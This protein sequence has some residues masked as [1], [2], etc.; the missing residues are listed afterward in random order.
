MKYCIQLV[1]F[2]TPDNLSLPGLLYEPSGKSEKVAIYLH[3]NGSSSIFYGDYKMNLYGDALTKKGI[4]FFPFNNRGAHWIKKLNKKING[5]EERILYGMTYELIKECIL[6]IDGAVEFLKT[7]GYKTFYLIGASTGANKIVVYHY[8]K[9][10]NPISKYILLSGGDDTGLYYDMEFKKN[11]KKF[12]SVLARC[13]KEIEKGSGRKLVPRYILKEPLIS[14]QSLYD[15]IN[16]DGDYNIFPFNEYM[17]NLRLS[18][19]Q[20]FREYKTI[21][22]PTLLVC[23]EKDEYCYGEVAQYVD[24]LR[25]EC[26]NQKLFT[27]E[28]IQ[29]ADHGFEGK[30]GELIKIISN[31]L[32]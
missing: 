20:L 2:K 1:S 5:K 15:T 32:T 28:I 17:N 3:G 25:K 9:P 30:E 18:K 27:F 10:K 16:P 22:K 31:W 6:D 13:K 8:Y 4:S 24:I 26:P 7:L 11:K 14:Y 23:G 12:S 19:K 21:N 29:D